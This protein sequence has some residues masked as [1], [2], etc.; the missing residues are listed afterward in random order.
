MRKIEVNTVKPVGLL[1]SESHRFI[2]FLMKIHIQSDEL[3]TLGRSEKYVITRF[4]WTKEFGVHINSFEVIS[5]IYMAESGIQVLSDY[6]KNADRLSLDEEIIRNTEK[7]F[8][9]DDNYKKWNGIFMSI[10]NAGERTKKENDK[11]YQEE[12]YRNMDDDVFLK[13]H[14]SPKE[15]ILLRDELVKQSGSVTDF[16]NI[17]DNLIASYNENQL[18]DFFIS[19]Y[20]CEEK[21]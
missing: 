16:K 3:D 14:L 15:S 13:N 10:H 21:I 19:L 5:P 7:H 1:N 2:I 4:Q 8:M 6:K 20:G 11:Y 12:E 17:Y 18:N 9:L